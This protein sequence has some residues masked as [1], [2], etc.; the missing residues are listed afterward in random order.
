MVCYCTSTSQNEVSLY[1]HVPFCSRKCIYC[2]FPSIVSADFSPYFE[3]VHEELKL[4][5]HMFEG[6]SIVSVYFGGG[7]P[8]RVPAC[9][10][11]DILEKTSKIASFSSNVEI[12]VEMNPEDVER[13]LLIEY[14]EMGVNRVSIGLQ[15]AEDEILFLLGRPHDLATFLKAFQLVHSFF[16]NVNVDFMIGLP[17]ETGE[18]VKKNLKVVRILHPEHVSVYL[19]EEDEETPLMDLV[20]R[21]MI[22]LPSEEETVLHY[23]TMV[24]GLHEQGYRRYEISNWTVSKPCL[25]NVRYWLNLDYIGLGIGA[26]GHVG[27]YRYVNVRD[28]KKYVESLSQGELPEEY[29]RQNDAHTELKETFFMCLRLMEGCNLKVLEERFGE[30]VWKMARSLMKK[31]PDLFLLDGDR[32][33]LSDTGILHSMHAME[34]LVNEED[35]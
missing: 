14:R 17:S 32:F 24:E 35:K 4:R 29:G 7:T 27:N 18:T 15:T 21:G 23:T 25:H 5:K 2:D 9:Y 6:K 1:V 13:N 11:A 33:K 12:T 16:D 8:S 3:A 34:L 31:A 20:K 10:L 26:G 22:S 19:L 28:M 30:V